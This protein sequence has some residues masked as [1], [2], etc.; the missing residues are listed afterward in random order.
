MWTR[1][2]F[3]CAKYPAYVRSLFNFHFSPM[4]TKTRF[5]QIVLYLPKKKFFD[6]ELLS[7]FIILWTMLLISI[8]AKRGKFAISI[9]CN[10]LCD[11]YWHTQTKIECDNSNKFRNIF[12]QPISVSMSK[13]FRTV[14]SLHAIRSPSFVFRCRLAMDAFDV[15]LC[16]V[17]KIT[18]IQQCDWYYLRARSNIRSIFYACHM[19]HANILEK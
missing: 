17:C 2:D 1:A 14:S 10:I 11:M 4:N 13:Q 15:C 12:G 3:L 6:F 8:Q 18:T 16:S 5:S 7:A 19:P 9:P